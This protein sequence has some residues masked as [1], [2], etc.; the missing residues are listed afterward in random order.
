MVFVEG[1]E[2]SL[3][4]WASPLEVSAAYQAGVNVNVGKCDGTELFKV[5]VENLSVN[6]VEIEICVAFCRGGLAYALL[7]RFIIFGRGVVSV[8]IEGGRGWFV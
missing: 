7:E 2:V 4:V 6:C 1:M 5:E 8:A 3:G